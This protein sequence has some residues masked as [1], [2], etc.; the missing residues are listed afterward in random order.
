MPASGASGTFAAAPLEE[1]IWALVR[2]IRQERPHVVV[3]YSD[4]QRGYQ[5]PDHLRVHDASV[6]A[7]K[8]AGDP[9]FHPKLGVAWTPQKLYYVVWSR[10]SLM[11]QHEAFLQL[12]LPSPYKVERWQRRPSMDYRLTTKIFIGDHWEQVQAALRA[13]ATQI[14]PDSKHWFGLPPDIA[15][16][17]YPYDDYILAQSTVPST[18]PEDDLFAGVVGD[19]VR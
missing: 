18:L 5:H 15:R 7:Y 4:N 10:A 1:T 3:T 16:I 13:H 6:P 2:L 19:D 14:N 17:T 11:A 9:A 8:A 12:G